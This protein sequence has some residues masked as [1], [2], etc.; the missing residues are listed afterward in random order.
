MTHPAFSR[1]PVIAFV[2]TLTVIGAM[3]AGAAGIPVI[4]VA[5]NAVVGQQAADTLRAWITQGAQMARTISQ[6]A[7]VIRQG[8]QMV[9]EGEMLY[10]NFTN[11][12]YLKNYAIGL[13]NREL[14]A[15]LPD[16]TNLVREAISGAFGFDVPP[17]M[18]L[19]G[20]VNGF[21]A[22]N[23]A[24][25][26]QGDDPQ[27]MRIRQEAGTNLVAS[28]LADQLYDTSAKRITNLNELSSRIG[29]Q[30]TAAARQDLG[31]RLAAEMVYSMEQNNQRAALQMLRDEE[32]T[33][34]QNIKDQLRRKSADDMVAEM[35]SIIASR[36]QNVT[37]NTNLAGLLP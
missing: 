14:R 5:L 3:N 37:S 28:S 35:N 6:G 30:A 32:K 18:G 16:D 26:P 25:Q 24:Y 21:L 15:P 7:E 1:G 4:D 10:N 17:G 23:V 20:L 29:E 11:P 34:Q 9:Q 36:G 22:T 33:R 12:T 2:G 27:A 8:A 13:A 19:G 31:N